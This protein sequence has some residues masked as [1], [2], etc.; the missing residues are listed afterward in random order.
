MPFQDLGRNSG[1][2]VC[3]QQTLFD[4]LGRVQTS[5]AVRFRGERQEPLVEEIDRG[6]DVSFPAMWLIGVQ[7]RRRQPQFA[8]FP[9]PFSP[10]D[11]PLSG[12]S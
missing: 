11:H 9:H 2:V 12:Q 8:S 3:V 4:L 6:G 10:P 7:P 1:E 5:F